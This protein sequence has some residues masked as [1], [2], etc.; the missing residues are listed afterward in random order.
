MLFTLAVIVIAFLVGFAMKRGGLCTYAAVIQIVH[1]R[2]LDRLLIFLGAA[3]WAALI[4]LP[5]A[6]LQPGWVHLTHT[7]YHWMIALVGGAILGVGAFFNKGCFFGTFVQLVSGN[8]NYLATLAGL[9][10][11]VIITRLYAHEHIPATLST[12]PVS[13][14]DAL[15][16]LWYAI[17]VFYA[18]FMALSVKLSGDSLIKKLA[19]LCSMGW[20][21]SFAM[22]IIG[23]GGG[24]LYGTVKGW[25]YA[26][27]VSN[28]SLKLFTPDALGPGNLALIS[29]LSMVTGGIVAAVSAREFAIRPARMMV[30]VSCFSGGLLMGAAS[31]LTPGGN[32]GLL[33]KGIPGFAP[34][35]IVDYIMMVLVMLL[36]VRLFRSKPIPAS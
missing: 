10:V 34:H 17:M 11:G 9:S 12:A 1:Q 24:L 19:G 31:L 8:L 14:P 20:Q 6:W 3:A 35:A 16:Y 21:N 28:F 23:I 32:D 33:L 30:I 26:D 22:V 27:V 2:R 5:I 15:A 18:L 13:Q 4:I 25:N 36:L 7:H 29:T